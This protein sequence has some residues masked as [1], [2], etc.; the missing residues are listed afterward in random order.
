MNVLFT[1]LQKKV[2]DKYDRKLADDYISYYGIDPTEMAEYAD[3]F[4]AVCY[5]FNE[6][7]YEHE[8]RMPD[9][10][11]FADVSYPNDHL[12]TYTY[13]DCSVTRMCF[14]N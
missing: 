9:E 11:P 7:T 5:K 8:P 1:K 4:V 13:G 14:R 6:E 10:L 2:I 3:E 12:I